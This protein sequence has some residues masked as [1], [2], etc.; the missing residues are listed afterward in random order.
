MFNNMAN[1]I[2]YSLIFSLLLT[3]IYAQEKFTGNKSVDKETA[4]KAGGSVA[5]LFKHYSQNGVKYDKYKEKGCYDLE[6]FGY[7]EAKCPH[8]KPTL[9]QV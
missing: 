8:C 4:K 3:S 7:N 1:L 6:V 2:K 9:T 5:W